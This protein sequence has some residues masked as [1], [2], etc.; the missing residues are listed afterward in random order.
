M[1]RQF[2]IERWQ[3]GQ[4]GFNKS[5]VNP[6]LLTHRAVLPKAE[7][8]RVLVPLCGKS[9]DMIW[10][11]QQ[12]YEVVG[13]E[14]SEIAVRDFFREQQLTAQVSSSPAGL[15]RYRAGALTLLCGDF[16]ALERADLGHV[17][18]FYDRAALVALPSELR[19]RYAAQLRT[20]LPARVLGLLVTFEYEQTQM[21]G[22]PF[23]VLEAEVRALYEPEFLVEP[24]A[25][26]DILDDE[27]RFRQAGLSALSERVYRLAR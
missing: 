14:L 13:V 9:V 7:G 11:A 17:D 19:A 16:F 25:S 2:W 27:P 5:E 26:Y 21:N 12:G 3:A 18:A 20:L 15:T 8:A 10:L 23:A 6:R 22:P 24:L 4:I 1:D